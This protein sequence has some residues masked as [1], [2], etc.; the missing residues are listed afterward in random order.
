MSTKKAPRPFWLRKT[1]AMSAA[2]A[3]M[4]TV[5]RAAMI[6]IGFTWT[7]AGYLRGRLLGR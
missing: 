5:A 4:M 3:A 2:A 7:V 1:A 6:V